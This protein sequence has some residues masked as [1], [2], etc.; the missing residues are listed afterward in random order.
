MGVESMA[1]GSIIT[2]LGSLCG[3]ILSKRRCKYTRNDENECDPKCAFSD[4]KLDDHHELDLFEQ[5]VDDVSL[6]II[7]KKT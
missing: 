1:L 2:T 5:K 3:V 7:T 4:Q 6:L